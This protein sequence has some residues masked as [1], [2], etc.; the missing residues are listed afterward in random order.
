MLKRFTCLIFL[1]LVASLQASASPAL[2]HVSEVRAG[3][4]GYGRTVFKGTQVVSFPVTVLGV[5]ENQIAASPLVLV[6]VDGGYPVAHHTG[7][8]AGM[9]GSPV[10]INGKL[11]GAIAYGW[12]FSKEPIGGVTPIDSMLT[13]LPTGTRVTA[14]GPARVEPAVSSAGP[15]PLTAPIAGRHRVQ[16]FASADAARACGPD[17]IALAPM[18]SLL[19]VQGFSQRSMERLRQAFKPLGLEPV[20]STMRAAPVRARMPHLEPGA[21]VGVQM[22]AGDLD[23]SSTGTLTWLDGK[24]FL[25]F[26]HSMAELGDVSI[27]ATAAYVQDILPSYSSSFKFASQ[28]GVIGELSSDRLYAVGGFLGRSVPMIPVQLHLDDASRNVHHTYHL[29]AI[30]H[31][32]L[33]PLVMTQ[34]ALE[35]LSTTVPDQTE[36]AARLSIDLHPVGHDP[37]HVEQMCSGLGVDTLVGAQMESIISGVT[38]N[39]FGRVALSSAD[40]RIEVLPGRH[41]A[42]IQQIYTGQQM[43]HAGENVDVHVVLKPFGQPSIERVVNVPLPPDL[44][45]GTV[46]IGVCGGADVAALRKKLNQTKPDPENLDQ[47]LRNVA[48]EERNQQLI[49]QLGFT[50]AAAHIGQ[51]RYGFL[52][53]ALRETLPGLTSSPLE[54]DKDTIEK[55]VDTEFV[56][57]GNEVVNTEVVL[58]TPPK[59]LRHKVP[60]VGETPV[61]VPSPTPSPT[62]T[63]EVH[64]TNVSTTSAATEKSLPSGTRRWDLE[65]PLAFEQGE[66]HGTTVSPRSEL[67]LAPAR[68]TV[69]DL[70][71]RFIWSMARAAEGTL[72]LGTA[73]DGKVFK[74][75]RSEVCKIDDGAVTALAVGGNG[76]LWIGTAPH[77]LLYRRSLDGQLRLLT[78]TGSNYIWC[79]APQADGSALVG[80]GVPATLL[81][82]SAAGGVHEV[83][84]FGERHVRALWGNASDL[85]VATANP[86]VVYHMEG[87]APRAVLS[88]TYGSID[89][90]VVKDGEISIISGKSLYRKKHDDTTRTIELDEKPLLA[91]CESSDGSLLAGSASGNVYR[92]DADDHVSTVLDIEGAIMALRPQSDGFVAATGGPSRVWHVSEATPTSGEWTSTVLDASGPAHWGRVRWQVDGVGSVALQTR[93]GFTP[94]PDASWSAWS[95]EYSSPAGQPISSP[96]GR[97][98]QVRARLGGTAAIASISLFYRP[99]DI[100]P[101]IDITSPTVGQHVSGTLK[102]EWKITSSAPDLI[103]FDVFASSDGGKEWKELASDLGATLASGAAEPPVQEY[104]WNTSGTA[105]GVYLIKVEAYDRAHPEHAA[106]V[107]AVSRPVVVTNTAPSIQLGKREELPNKA[108]VRVHGTAVAHFSYITSVSYRHGTSGTWEMALP[109]GGTYDSDHVSFSFVSTERGEVE[110]RATDEAGNARTVKF[111]L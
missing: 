77:G 9:S 96:P 41:S 6:R 35:A 30:S 31:P 92:V 10:Y 79:I 95:G 63:P 59:P 76:D 106:R 56:L 22:L 93:S 26:G 36:T 80:T 34:A 83:Q 24:R 97:Y 85:Y 75:D 81:E 52:P 99:Q 1:I 32:T 28:I 40:V 14:A 72:Y 103:G 23:V 68:D 50:S 53:Q 100:L 86:G 105:D 2:M 45:K 87:G 18:G 16:I 109:D 104:S 27:P 111:S 69:A 54:S 29:R 70:G 98:L 44:E 61:V 82:V 66:H 21:A 60:L 33:S 65:T 101:S 62:P 110:V 89:G 42:T 91:L 20:R 25:A 88:T 47:Y 38:H 55:R 90:L 64:V 108:G 78:K 3:M 11:L 13:D 43:Y 8:I 17:T 19:E 48:E 107:E 102:I 73:D 4:R 84:R 67:T 57:K 15:A 58:D 49:V 37:I 7:I 46:S 5:V 71:G 74:A 39:E 51:D 94:V 12:P